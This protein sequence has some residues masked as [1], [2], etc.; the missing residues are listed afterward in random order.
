V[1]VSSQS[2]K[3]ESYKKK[4]NRSLNSTELIYRIGGAGIELEL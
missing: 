1:T 4:M 3:H 2:I